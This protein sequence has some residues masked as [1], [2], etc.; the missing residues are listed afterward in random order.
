MGRGHNDKEA[1]R[2]QRE[3]NV[4]EPHSSCPPPFLLSSSYTISQP[5]SSTLRFLECCSVPG[6]RTLKG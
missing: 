1:A 2:R 6:I 5:L 3:R 4:E